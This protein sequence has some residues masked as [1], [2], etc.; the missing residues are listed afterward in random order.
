[1]SVSIIEAIRN[2]HKSKT[3]GNEVGVTWCPMDELR[4]VKQPVGQPEMCEAVVN[5]AGVD[6]VNE[7]VL[8]RGADPSY[9]KAARAV[10]Y[11]HDAYGSSLPVGTLRNLS[12]RAN[13]DR[14]VMSWAWSANEFAQQVRVAVSEGAVSGCS[15]GFI[16]TNRGKLSEDEKAVYGDAD[17]IV[18]SWLWLE[19]SVTPAPCNPEALI[20]AKS[21][22]LSESTIHCLEKLVSKGRITKSAARMMGL[23]EP[24]PMVR[25]VLMLGIYQ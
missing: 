5:T 22:D 23:P 11:N 24:K 16:P 14:W 17:S 3:T 10:F 18:R 9:F 4:H 2:R 1:M 20:G 13:P 12:M 8:P 19:T 6:L 15:V 21:L 25:K 7:V